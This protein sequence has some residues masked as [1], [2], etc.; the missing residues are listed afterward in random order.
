VTPEHFNHALI[1]A[2][3]L[4]LLAF[5]LGMSALALIGFSA[6]HPGYFKRKFK[7]TI[8]SAIVKIENFQKG[9]V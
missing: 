5:S 3:V 6:D 4:I 2:V 7:K 8:Y 9:R 1:T